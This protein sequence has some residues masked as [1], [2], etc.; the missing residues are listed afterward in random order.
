MAL[1]P[2]IQITVDDSLHYFDANWFNA[3][4]YTSTEKSDFSKSV[5]KTAAIGDSWACFIKPV[6]KLWAKKHGSFLKQL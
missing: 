3:S 1:P 2:T 4:K 6:Y 5:G